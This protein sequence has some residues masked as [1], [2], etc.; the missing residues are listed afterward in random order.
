VHRRRLAIAGCGQVVRSMARHGTNSGGVWSEAQARASYAVK[1]DKESPLEPA[2]TDHLLVDFFEHGK[3]AYVV[4]QQPCV[5]SNK[6]QPSEARPSGP[7]SREVTDPAASRGLSVNGWPVLE[8]DRD[9]PRAAALPVLPQRAGQRLLG[10]RQRATGVARRMRRVSRR[11]DRLRQKCERHTAMKQAEAQTG[12]KA[13][14][15]P[16]EAPDVART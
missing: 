1:P 3:T 7:R 4:D 2:F 12:G 8:T 9:H 14:Q 16:A 5:R 11:V 15:T 10:G 13:R 6:H